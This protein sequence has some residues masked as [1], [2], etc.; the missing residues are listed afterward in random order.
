MKKTILAYL[1]RLMVMVG[2]IFVTSS[3]G[4]II[5]QRES[6]SVSEDVPLSEFI[7]GR[8]EY[9]G[10]HKYENS[11][12]VADVSW[13][14]TFVNNKNVLIWTT[15]DGTTCTYEFVEAELLSI[16]CS[17]RMIELMTWSVKRDGQDLLI[18]RL[19]NGA[20]GNGELLKFTRVKIR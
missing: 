8:W 9:E 13:V 4:T 18:Q 11:D 1:I 17:P 16:D 15:Y 14:Y 3:C 5:S 6:L 12:Y 20:N 2:F 7:I 10:T 19:D